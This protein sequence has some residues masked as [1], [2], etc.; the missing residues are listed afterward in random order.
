[1][2]KTLALAMGHLDEVLM[3]CYLLESASVSRA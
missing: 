1:M 2:A 3:A